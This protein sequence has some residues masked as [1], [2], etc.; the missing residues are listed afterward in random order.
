MQGYAFAVM[1]QRL[2]A[3]LRLRLLHAALRQET[4]WFDA[5]ENSSGALMSKLSSDAVLVRV[6]EWE[7]LSSLCCWCGR[8]G[9]NCRKGHVEVQPLA[10]TCRWGG[11]FTVLQVDH[12]QG[13]CPCFQ[14]RGAV[15]DQVGVL[16]QNLACVVGA[17]IIGFICSWKVTLVG[18]GW[19]IVGRPGLGYCW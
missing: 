10:S 11:V 15:A 13:H 1:G 2:A 12:L 7:R 17:Y 6:H 16:V 14:V 5:E 9:S 18:R 19:D 8:R 3:R 4:G